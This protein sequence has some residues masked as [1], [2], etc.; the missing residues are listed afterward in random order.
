M[1]KP[2]RRNIFSAKSIKERGDAVGATY[3]TAAIRNPYEPER[4]WEGEFLVDT[5]ATDSL[6]PR[7][8][9]EAIGIAPKAQR[10]YRL[11]D[12]NEI[13]LDIAGADIEFLGESTYG[14]V[15]FGAENA[16]P[17]L[18]VTALESVGI[19]V[20]PHNQT[21][22]KLSSVHMRGLRPLFR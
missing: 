7:Q 5:G 10:A 18:G 15:I 6:V 17:L 11:A 3:I 16:V 12:G 14:T 8:H 2:R 4:V 19:E 13:Q 1:I 20:D 9:L 21:L 22:T